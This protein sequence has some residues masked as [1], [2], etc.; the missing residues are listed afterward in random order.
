MLPVYQRVWISVVEVYK[1]VGKFVFPSVNRPKRLR[2]EFKAVKL[3]Q[4]NFLVLC[5]CF[6][7][8]ILKTLHLQQLKGMERAKVRMCNLYHFSMEGIPK[9]CLFLSEGHIKG[10]RLDLRAEPPPPPPPV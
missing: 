10:K 3:S 9:G 8:H 5:F 6:V 4:K 2:E 1:R 7:F